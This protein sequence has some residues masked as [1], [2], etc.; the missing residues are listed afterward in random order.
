MNKIRI[1]V[2]IG[3]SALAAAMALTLPAATAASRSGPPPA[4]SA[5]VTGPMRA[6]PAIHYRTMLASPRALRAGTVSSLN[7]SGYAVTASSGQTI[8]RM[9]ALLTIPDVNCARSTLGSSGHAVFSDWVG[10]DG[11]SSTSHTV[12]QTGVGADC[13]S[14]TGPATYFAFYEMFPNA[15]VTFTGVSPGDAIVV[16]V[17]RVST[18]WEL[19]LQDRTNGAAITTVQRCPSGSTCRDANGEVITEDFNGSV[20]AGFN[21]A[22]FG[23]DNQT[24]LLATSGSG[25][26]GSLGSGGLWTSSTID[27]VNGTHRMATPGPLY[28]GEAF[29][30][31]WNASS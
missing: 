31:G 10:L 21:L 20:P 22:D 17:Q 4:G 14:T 28:G 15:G 3:A 13:A 1:S 23:L 11:F 25:R 29:Y 18:G 30:L 12:E 24:D 16:I 5:R 26:S 7:W 8:G 2:I 9:Q 6:A 27:M 19:V